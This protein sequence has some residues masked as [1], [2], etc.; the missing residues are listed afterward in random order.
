MIGVRVLDGETAIPVQAMAMELRLSLQTYLIHWLR[1]LSLDILLG[2]LLF[3]CCTVN[4]MIQ[5]PC[6][7]Q[8]FLQL[9]IGMLQGQAGQG[10]KKMANALAKVVDFMDR[11]KPGMYH[12]IHFVGWCAQLCSNCVQSVTRAASICKEL[13]VFA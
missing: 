5:A 4:G 9:Q 13:S 6:Q 7:L 2:L 11:N 8:T 10:G 3:L 1:D 12:D